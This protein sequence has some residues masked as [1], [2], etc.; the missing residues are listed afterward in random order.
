MDEHQEL[1]ARVRAWIEANHPGV[2]DFKLPQSALEVA[3]DRQLDWLRAWQQKVY[4]AGF[5]GAEWPAEYGGGG[6]PRGTQ[7]AI[8]QELARARAPFLVNLVG[9]SWAGPI[10]LQ[11]GS[12]AQ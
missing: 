10:I 1:R 4:A 9:L 5:V 12:E 7:R 8:D 6:K 3:G 11:A 2:P